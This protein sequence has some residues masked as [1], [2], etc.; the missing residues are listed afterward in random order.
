MWQSYIFFNF[1][2]YLCILYLANISVFSSFMPTTFEIVLTCVSIHNANVYEV[3]S[4][5]HNDFTFG[6]HIWLNLE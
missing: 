3:F 4:D 5:S 1:Y 6:N 2:D